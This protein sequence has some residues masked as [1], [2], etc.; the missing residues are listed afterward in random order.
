LIDMVHFLA[1]AARVAALCHGDFRLGFRDRLALAL[2]AG[3]DRDLDEFGKGGSG[4]GKAV[5]PNAAA[6][7]DAILGAG[8]VWMAGHIP[9]DFCHGA[10]S[11]ASQPICNLRVPFD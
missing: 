4:S 7:G 6:T 5:S 2:G 11:F 10:A 9:S 8:S 1:T 3:D